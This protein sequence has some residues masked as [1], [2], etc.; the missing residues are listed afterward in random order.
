MIDEPDQSAE[1]FEQQVLRHEAG[2]RAKRR[3]RVVTLMIAG[4]LLALGASMALYFVGD[5]STT[6]HV[7]GYV[8]SG[9]VATA[10]VAFAAR[11][12]A[13]ALERRSVTAGLALMNI[14]AFAVAVVHAVSLTTRWL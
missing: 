6:T 13:H 2:R 5:G 12:A 8:S 14:A 3:S 9:L 4:A 11:M 7:I 10:L 1:E